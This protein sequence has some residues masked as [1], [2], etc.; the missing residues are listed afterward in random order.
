MAHA[1]PGIRTARGRI[2]RA[3]RLAR[4]IRAEAVQ[5]DRPP[6][7]VHAGGPSLRPGGSTGLCVLFRLLNTQFDWAGAMQFDR[8]TGGRCLS[9]DQAP[10]RS[11]HCCPPCG[12]SLA[13]LG[14]SGR[15]ARAQPAH[16]RAA[17]VHAHERIADPRL[18]TARPCAASNAAPRQSATPVR[19]SASSECGSAVEAFEMCRLGLV[20]SASWR[21]HDRGPLPSPG[22]VGPGQA[23]GRARTDRPAAPADCCAVGPARPG[24]LYRA[25]AERGLDDAGRASLPPAR[26]EMDPARKSGP[27]PGRAGPAGPSNFKPGLAAEFFVADWLPARRVQRMPRRCIGKPKRGRALHCALERDVT[28]VTG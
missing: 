10:A 21:E 27:Q 6:R 28:A 11:L 26:R 4:I 17:S 5:W 13:A 16:P 23:S 9:T 20:D 18:H 14:N 19:E 8:L 7:S 3:V 2:V 1:G 12:P 25:R 22:A 24:S 15:H